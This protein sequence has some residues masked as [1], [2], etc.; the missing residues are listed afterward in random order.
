MTSAHVAAAPI[1][2][3]V[4]EVPGW[5]YQLSRERVLGRDGRARRGCDRARPRRIPPRGPGR[6]LRAAGVLRPVRSGRL[7]DPGTARTGCWTPYLKP[8]A[9]WTGLVRTGA[10]VM[11]VAAVSGQEGYDQ[12]LD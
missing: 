9:R 10:E 7:C 3:G 4:C 6:V 2:W 8:S 11:V 1:S 5:G 12:A